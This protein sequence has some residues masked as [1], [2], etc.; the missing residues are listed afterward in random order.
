[1][2]LLFKLVLVCVDFDVVVVLGLLFIL[3]CCVAGLLFWGLS[4]V[5]V[6]D[7]FFVWGTVLL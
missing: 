2:S 7:M 5:V 1:M 6:F 3:C 4:P